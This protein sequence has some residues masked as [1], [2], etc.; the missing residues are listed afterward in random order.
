MGE[1][2]LWRAWRNDTQ[3]GN[4]SWDSLCGERV[5]GCAGAGL[6][7]VSLPGTWSSDR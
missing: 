1:Y 2:A 4:L 3:A 5:S 7:Q 6:G